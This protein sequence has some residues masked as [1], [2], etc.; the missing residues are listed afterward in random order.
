M[1]KIITII[2]VIVVL[3]LGFRWFFKS[4]TPKSPLGNDA[5]TTEQTPINTNLTFKDTAG[6]FELTYPKDFN[7]ETLN[8][9]NNTW[10]GNSTSTGKIL[11]KI[12]LPKSI[13]PMTNF[14]EASLVVASST[15]NACKES[16]QGNNINK[17]SVSIN[18]VSFTKYSYAD[19][20]AG[21]FYD[22]TSYRTV[23]G[24]T[25]FIL[26]Y[27]IH[28]TNIGNYSPDQGIKEFDKAK[29]TSLLENVVNSFKFTK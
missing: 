4:M 9:E 6:V 20:G 24:N 19:A 26:E 3:I 1:K 28:S 17:S 25:C 14:S 15:I 18:N 8:S 11:A 21:N 13:E 22:V 2:L 5:T 10:Y 23:K 16:P 7:V 29:I 12:T 27:T